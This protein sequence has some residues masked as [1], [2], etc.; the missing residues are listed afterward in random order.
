MLLDE[1]TSALDLATERKVLSNMLSGV[2]RRTVIVTTHRPT[3]LLSCARVYSIDEGKARV[4]TQTEIDALTH[5]E[6]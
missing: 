1:A 2:H 5:G 4:L 6:A 3:V